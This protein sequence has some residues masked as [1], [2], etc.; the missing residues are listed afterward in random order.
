LTRDLCY[1]K[2]WFSQSV[3]EEPVQC[4]GL[5]CSSDFCSLEVNLTPAQK[6]LYL[7]EGST[8]YVSL[9]KSN[10]VEWADTGV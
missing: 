7:F 1:E 5:Y 4:E 9:A 2:E 8:P 6:K 10:R 3:D